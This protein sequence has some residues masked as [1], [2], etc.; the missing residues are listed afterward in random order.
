MDH[1]RR[2]AQRRTAHARPSWSRWFDHRR[3]V[4]RR[5]GPCATHSFVGTALLPALF[6]MATTVSMS[7]AERRREFG[8]RGAAGATMR[9]IR[10]IVRWEAAAVVTLGTILGLVIAMGTLVLLHLTSGSSYLRPAPQ[11]W[12]FPLVAAGAA[13]ATSTLPA[14]R[15]ASVPVLEAAR[16]E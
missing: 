14:R 2:S 15:A 6:G 9:Q 11:W 7:V 10:S 3:T 8:L 1:D 12:L 16:A 5:C 13:V 4:G